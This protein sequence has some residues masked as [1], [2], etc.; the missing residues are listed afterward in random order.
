MQT[1]LP[2]ESASGMGPATLAEEGIAVLQELE[3][4][5]LASIRAVLGHDASVLELATRDQLRLRRA[6]E[7]LWARDGK[8]SR[9]TGRGTQFTVPANTEC[10]DPLLLVQRR[11]L[12]QWKRQFAV[13]RC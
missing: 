11:V 5:L 9:I 2:T 12:H 4:S 6:L 1:P 7:I 3:A 8:L 13:R 10:D